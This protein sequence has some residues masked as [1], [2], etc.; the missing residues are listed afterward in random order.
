M[1][2]FSLNPFGQSLEICLH[3][4][5]RF[6]IF[7]ILTN[8]IRELLNQKPP[9]YNRSIALPPRDKLGMFLETKAKTGSN[10]DKLKF[11]DFVEKTQ[12]LFKP[13]AEPV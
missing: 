7:Q 5:A 12:K 13:W 6:V 10:I 11:S 8:A 1:A 9:D 4:L 3:V 2:I